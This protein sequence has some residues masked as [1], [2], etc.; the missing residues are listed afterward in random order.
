MRQMSKHP[1]QYRE[2]PIDV[3]CI[4]PLTLEAERDPSLRRTCRTPPAPAV[5]GF[6]P[7]PC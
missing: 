5:I 7:V 6:C 4:G 3:R 1:A 2:S